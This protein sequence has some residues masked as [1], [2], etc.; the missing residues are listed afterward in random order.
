MAKSLKSIIG[1]DKDQYDH[2]DDASYTGY[3]AKSAKFVA[4]HSK[5]DYHD[6]R[7]GAKEAQFTGSKKAPYPRADEDINEAMDS[8]KAHEILKRLE[9]KRGENVYKLP[10][11]KL[12]ELADEAKKH[13]Y[14]KPKNA[15]GSTGRYFH[16][17]LQ[18]SASKSRLDD[19]TEV[20][21]ISKGL[22]S[23]YLKKVA[24]R[25]GAT[26][27]KAAEY[28]HAEVYLKNSRSKKDKNL[29]AAKS[30][31]AALKLKNHEKGAVR[32]INRLTKEEVITEGMSHE[33]H[34]LVLHADNDSNLHRQSH[35][36]I[37][38]NLKRKHAKG[39]YDSEKAKKLWGYHADRAAQSYA[40]QHGGGQ[41]WHH[42]FPPRVRKE[43]AAH[44][45]SRKSHLEEEVQIDELSKKTLKS[46]L[47]EDI[48]E[49][50]DHVNVHPGSL[51]HSASSINDHKAAATFHQNMSQHH[52]SEMGDYENHAGDAK[53]NGHKE[54]HSEYQKAVTAHADLHAIHSKLAELHQHKYNKTVLGEAKAV[55][56]PAFQGKPTFHGV[57]ADGKK[58]RNK[59]GRPIAYASSEAAVAG[60][61][62]TAAQS[63]KKSK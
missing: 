11:S 59:D 44:W 43:A 4:A 45:E 8:V 46:Y 34:E 32:A 3:K 28:A 15:N 1:K 14:R 5:K 40:K 56:A 58:V 17:H 61:K 48:S 6:D 49:N 26:G 21:E 31:K 47:K 18:R 9:I 63:K 54:L 16:D 12:G 41:P 13:G 30:D 24:G 37:I 23:R 35:E 57:T 19:E 50:W 51:S 2:V 20:N 60:A 10:L 39:V 62:Y 29:W 25:F 52:Y 7:C 38:K 27:D 22:A 33:A 42:M 53:S 36:P 55:K